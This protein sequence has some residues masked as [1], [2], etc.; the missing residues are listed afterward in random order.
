MPE[1]SDP[2]GNV[3]ATMSLFSS[4]PSGLKEGF[5]CAPLGDRSSESGAIQSLRSD[6]VQAG[7][8]LRLVRPAAFGPSCCP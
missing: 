8:A 7:S 1:I 5:S 6:A 3:W 2:R 4:L